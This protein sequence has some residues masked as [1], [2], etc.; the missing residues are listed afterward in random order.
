MFTLFW[1]QFHISW[2]DADFVIIRCRHDASYPS[3]PSACYLVNPVLDKLTQII[4]RCRLALGTVTNINR[5]LGEG[6]F[7][8][9]LLSWHGICP[10]L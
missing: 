8:V 6:S 7:L 1:H 2:D 5:A 10:G 3:S 9:W 4:G